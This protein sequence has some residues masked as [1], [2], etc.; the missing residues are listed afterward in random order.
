[1]YR[2]TTHG[3]N[4][5]YITCDSECT[6]RVFH[7]SIPVKPSLSED[8]V[9]FFVLEFFQD[10]ILRQHTILTKTPL[11]SGERLMAILAPCFDL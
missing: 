5:T 6:T 1:M 11:N 7:M 10:N 2:R 9:T 3:I 8:D 4:I